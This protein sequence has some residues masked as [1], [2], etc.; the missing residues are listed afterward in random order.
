MNWRIKIRI[1]RNED[2]LN[3]S[4]YKLVWNW[5]RYGG[6]V[7]TDHC[8]PLSKCYVISKFPSVIIYDFHKYSLEKKNIS[9]C[10]QPSYLLFLFRSLTVLFLNF[11][12]EWRKVKWK[13]GKKVPAH[14]RFAGY[15]QLMLHDTHCHMFLNFFSLSKRCNDLTS[16]CV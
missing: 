5:L 15:R 1:R 13:Y 3:I 16:P 7:D 9:I 14:L 12:Q 8:S 2:L 4:R 6:M 10:S 11:Y